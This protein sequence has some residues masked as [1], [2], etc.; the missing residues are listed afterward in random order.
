MTGLGRAAAGAVCAS[1]LALG[2]AATAGAEDCSA[3]NWKACKGKPWVD[4]DDMET[5]LGSK[6]WP[7][8]QWGA[9]DEAGSTNYYT[10]PEILQ[11]AL[12]ANN[13]EKVYNLGPSLLVEMPLFGARKF[14]MHIPGLPAGGPFGAD[15]LV[16]NDEFIATEIG[17]VGTQ[18]DGFGHIGVATEGAR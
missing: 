3:D 10:Q 17:Q 6:W 1:L 16:Y 14:V 13:A 5:P 18:F 12:A 11:R 7:N 9:D 8:E 4:G 15:N 2:W